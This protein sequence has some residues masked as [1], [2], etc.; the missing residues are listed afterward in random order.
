M[1]TDDLKYMSAPGFASLKSANIYWQPNRY[2]NYEC[3]Y[4]FPTSHTKIK[5]FVDKDL[6]FQTIDK[7]VQKFTERGI[8]RINW[9]WSGGEATFHPNFLDFQKR[10][11]THEHMAMTFNMTTNLSHNLPWWKKF[12]DTTKKYK[13]IQ[14]S[15]SL[16]QEYVKTSAQI[17]KFLQKLDY[18]RS[19]GIKVTINQ[20]MD[21]DIF[22]EQLKGLEKFYENDYTI[23]PKINTILHKEYLKYNGS[24][25]YSKEQLEI[26]NKSHEKR[27]SFVTVIDKNNNN[28][29]FHSFEQIK[30]LGLWDLDDWICSAG[31]LSL[32]IENNTVKRGVGG[33]RH[34]LLGTLDGGW[35]LHDEPQ[36]CRAGVTCTC[37]ADLKLPKWNPKHDIA[38]KWKDT[39]LL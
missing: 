8:Q 10:I 35:D 2:C 4:C 3:S 16:H 30:N 9:G 38:S 26:M 5:D 31:Y 37:T 29:D 21:P 6:A 39:E 15:A 22:D 34:Q 17:D 24:T 23:S 1:K 13:N 7:C 12:V 28:I 19:N 18:L 25:I 20:V 36:M 14:V 33:C 11:L 32:T 27:K